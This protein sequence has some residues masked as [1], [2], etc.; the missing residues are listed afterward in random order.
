MSIVAAD[1]IAHHARVSP[2]REAVHDIASNRHLTYAQFD[3]RITRLA[4]YLQSLGIAEGDRVAVLSHNDSD[5]FEI[6]FACQRLGA[7]LLPLNW[8]LAVPELEFV[9]ND[10]TPNAL[11]FGME[12]AAVASDLVGLTDVSYSIATNNGGDSTYDLAKMI[13]QENVDTKYAV[14]S[15]AGEA[16]IIKKIR[17]PK[18]TADE[19]AENI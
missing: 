7:I 18:M 19:L 1:W 8:R 9:C 4:L 2:E 5:V 6:Q 13:K 15:I 12:F 17:V 11:I 3:G 16:V 10:A 14:A